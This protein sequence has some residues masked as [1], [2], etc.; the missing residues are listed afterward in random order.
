MTLYALLAPTRQQAFAPSLPPIAQAM[1]PAGVAQLARATACHAVGREFES[2][3]P[4]QKEETQVCKDLGFFFFEEA[5][6]PVQVG[7]LAFRFP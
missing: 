1:P 6:S 3:R 2:H 4:L 7:T 5:V